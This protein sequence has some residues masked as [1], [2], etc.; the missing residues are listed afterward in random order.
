[1]TLLI[2]FCS[3]LTGEC[4]ARAG[5]T[6]ISGWASI[7]QHP[8]TTAPSHVL[9]PL[10]TALFNGISNTAPLPPGFSFSHCL[11]T[12]QFPLI[13][14]TM[15]YSKEGASDGISCLSNNR[16]HQKLWEKSISRDTATLTVCAQ[17][18]VMSFYWGVRMFSCML[19]L[20]RLGYPF[21]VPCKFLCC[22]QRFLQPKE[23]HGEGYL[24]FRISSSYLQ[25]SELLLLHKGAP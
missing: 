5:P 2:L 1:M 14:N 3:L 19:I 23:L 15:N 4:Y 13:L 8:N 18:T 25:C 6:G 24:C 17:M 10:Q 9:V 11:C 7:P 16:K 12:S 22:L 20:L 21:Q